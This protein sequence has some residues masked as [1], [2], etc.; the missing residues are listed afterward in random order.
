MAR[1]VLK[2]L[3]WMIPIVVG[4]TI[5]IFTIMYFIPGDPVKIMM[6]SAT[7]EEIELAREALGYNRGYFARLWDYASGVFFHLDLGTS[8]QLGS[9]VTSDLVGRFPRTVAL[10]LASMALSIVLGVP[11]G[12]AAA[13]HQ[14]SIGDRVAMIVAMVGVSMPAFW[15]GLLL[16]QLFSVKLQWLPAYGIGGLKYY[17]L[18]ALSN[19]FAGVAGFAR[20][21]RSSVL[22]NIRSDYVTT[23]RSKGV[24][25]ARVL[26][27][28]IIPNSLIPVITYAGTQFSKLL[29]GAIVIEGVFSIPG[30]GT[31]MINGINKRDYGAVQGSIIFSAV[32]FSLVMLLVDVIYAYV[33]PRIKAQY[34]NKAKARRKSNA[35]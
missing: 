9:S 33:D 32:T 30:L 13:T 19:C 15:L 23:A 7:D 1:Y 10:A 31:Y 25:E 27:R 4:V 34:E 17:I 3:L 8:W 22:E 28:H 14:N 20:Q 18:P 24:P 29:A 21:M 2:R 12:I 11:L 26:W 35:A 5:L 16:V 6:P